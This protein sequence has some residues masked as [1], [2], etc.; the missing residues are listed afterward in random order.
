MEK[1]NISTIRDNNSNLR[2]IEYTLFPGKRSPGK[3]A[4]QTSKIGNLLL[5]IGK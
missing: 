2:L 1:N 3:Y 4:I 5:T